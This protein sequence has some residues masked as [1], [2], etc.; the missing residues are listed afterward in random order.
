MTAFTKKELMELKAREEVL[1]NK[2]YVR[3]DDSD[4][5]LLRREIRLLERDLDYSKPKSQV[6][7]GRELRE[8]MAV[9]LTSWGQYCGS[10]G[11]SSFVYGG[12]ALGALVKKAE[13][14]G[15]EMLGLLGYDHQSLTDYQSFMITLDM[16]ISRLNKIDRRLLELEYKIMSETRARTWANEFGRSANTYRSRKSK[17]LDDLAMEFLK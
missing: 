17:L 2:G 4:E 3:E 6:R 1:L 9:H 11:E 16:R 15:K 12:T 7:S 8:R 13:K 14:L 10:S 5:G